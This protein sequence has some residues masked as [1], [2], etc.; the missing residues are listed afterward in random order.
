MPVLLTILLVTAGSFGAGY[1]AARYSL[2]RAKLKPSHKGLLVAA[3]AGGSVIVLFLVL[4][5]FGIHLFRE[6]AGDLFRAVLALVFLSIPARM[7]FLRLRSGSE[8]ADLGP[9]PLRTIFLLAAALLMVAGAGG[10]LTRPFSYGQSAVS[11]AQAVSL[12]ALGFAHSE[13]RS[14]G[15][16]SGG[17]LLRWERIA[18]YRWTNG[19]V[20]VVDLHRP[21][22]WQDRVQLRVPTVLVEQVDRL[23]F[24]HVLHRDS[25]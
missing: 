17:G 14:H 4:R 12:A 5:Q 3:L 20:L 21:R 7:I 24:Q 22:W 11:L 18:Q 6:T 13:I 2:K 8:L 16:Y 1:L 9:S 19:H 25:D 23:M 10:L 15:I